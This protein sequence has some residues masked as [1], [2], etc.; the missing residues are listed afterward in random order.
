MKRWMY[1]FIDESSLR[2]P[3]WRNNSEIHPVSTSAVPIHSGEDNRLFWQREDCFPFSEPAQARATIEW[4]LP[5][6]VVLK[7]RAILNE[8]N[9]RSEIDIITEIH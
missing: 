4:L 5:V 1:I 3:H 6:A 7:S 9:E 2:V 8:I